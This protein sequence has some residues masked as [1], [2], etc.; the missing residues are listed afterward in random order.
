M[1]RWPGPWR[2]R[3]GASRRSPRSA[4]RRRRPCAHAGDLPRRRQVRLRHRHAAASRRASMPRS[5]SFSMSSFRFVEAGVVVEVLAGGVVACKG[6]YLPP[7]ETGRRGGRRRRCDITRFRPDRVRFPAPAE[8]ATVWTLERRPAA[9]APLNVGCSKGVEIELGRPWPY[10]ATVGAQRLGALLM[11]VGGRCHGYLEGGG[12][13]VVQCPSNA[14]QLPRNSN[15]SS[16]KSNQ[17]TTTMF[18]ITQNY[19]GRKKLGV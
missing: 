4:G 11:K 15:G 13:V 1:P 3:L 2:R 12:C 10:R 8:S 17:V 18:F 9:V 16:V 7:V 14:A 19:S 6:A 5:A